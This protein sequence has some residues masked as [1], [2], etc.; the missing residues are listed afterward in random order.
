MALAWSY[1]Y[2]LMAFATSRTARRILSVVA[3]LTG[4]W[5]KYLDHF[6][7]DRPG[8]YDAGSAYYFLGRKSDSA[9]SD[10]DLISLYRGCVYY[11]V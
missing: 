9:I 5:L 10:A 3:R 7:L 2:F 1:Q 11:A 6:L 8:A 4:F